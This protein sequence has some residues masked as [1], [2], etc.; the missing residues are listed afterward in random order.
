M[1]FLWCGVIFC[2]GDECRLSSSNIF[3]DWRRFFSLR[4]SRIFWGCCLRVY[5]YL[6]FWIELCMFWILWCWWYM[7]ICCVWVMVWIRR[8]SNILF[9]RRFRWRLKFFLCVFYL[10]VCIDKWL[11]MF[12]FFVFWF[13]IC[14][15]CFMWSVCLYLFF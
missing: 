3:R 8:V 4:R 1:V 13:N 10:C 7:L 11:D 9:W 12:C 5:L 14:D 15:D 6:S 2:L